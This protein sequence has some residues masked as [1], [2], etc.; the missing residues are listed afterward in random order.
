M[1]C[2]DSRC[3]TLVLAMTFDTP[4]PDAASAS[5]GRDGLAP[6][7]WPAAVPPPGVPGWERRAVAWLF[8]L[9]PPDFRAYQVL[10]AY[11]VLLARVA[12]EHVAAG[13]QACRAGLSSVRA[14]LRDVVAADV[15]ETAV[16]MYEREGARLTR[17]AREVELVG[18]ALRGH[19]FV[20]RL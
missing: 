1:I 5:R 18:Q 16:G 8:D 4:H 20:P 6:A 3:V 14:D 17:S 19:R 12:R 9:C 11:P 7:G 10:R 2:P 13:I 15:V